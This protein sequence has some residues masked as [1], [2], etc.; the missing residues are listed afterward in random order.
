L[1]LLN[2]EN[3]LFKGNDWLR[4]TYLSRYM[5]SLCV[6]PTYQDEL[7]QFM[8]TADRSIVS[9]DAGLQLLLCDS[10]IGRFSRVE[11]SLSVAMDS[12][13]ARDS[14]LRDSSSLYVLRVYA[15]LDELNQVSSSTTTWSRATA[16][17][18]S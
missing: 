17:I 12:F 8:D 11:A 18:R 4:L 15:E 3:D 1:E 14:F 5:S 9:R 16:S 6:V 10:A 2:R 13:L 7:A